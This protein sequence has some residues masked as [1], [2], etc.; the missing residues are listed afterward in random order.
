MSDHAPLSLLIEMI[1]LAFLVMIAIRYLRMNKKRPLQAVMSSHGMSE[2]DI[3]KIPDNTR[4]RWVSSGVSYQ[5]F[6]EQ[7]RFHVEN[8]I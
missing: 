6:T 5:E 2:K 3:E 4:K 7:Y 8:Q 1:G